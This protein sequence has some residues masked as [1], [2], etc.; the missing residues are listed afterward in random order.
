MAPSEDRFRMLEARCSPF[1]AELL[2]Q[3]RTHP[4]FPELMQSL[5]EIE[6]MIFRGDIEEIF[7]QLTAK[8]E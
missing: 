5:E 7:A 1:A 6:G 2:H 3:L 8:P 4:K